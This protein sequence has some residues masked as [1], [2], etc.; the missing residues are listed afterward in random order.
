MKRLHQLPSAAW[1]NGG[2]IQIPTKDLPALARIKAFVFRLEGVF[3][4]G[5]AAAAIAS[6]QLHRLISMIDAGPLVRASGQYWRSLEWATRGGQTSIPFGLPAANNEVHRRHITWTIPFYDKRSQFPGDDCPV[7]AEYSD[8]VIQIETAAFAGLGAGTWD[9][10]ANLTGTLRVFALLD[11]PNDAPASQVKFG[12]VDLTGQAP[13]MDSGLYV[14]AFIYRES[15]AVITSAQVATVSM[16]VDGTQLADITRLSEYARIFNDLHGLGSDLETAHATTPVAGEQLPETP[17]AAAGSADT[18]SVPFVPLI[19]PAPGY[20]RSQGVRVESALRV[21]YTG[22]D[23]SIRV[24]FRKI[25]ARSES[26]AIQAFQR[27]GRT[28]VRSASQI[29]AKTGSKRGLTEGKA[30]LWRFLP[31]RA[32]SSR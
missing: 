24:G 8:K 2:N 21:D 7:G 25:V 30:H 28:D 17:A 26:D 29:G 19:T 10:L 3:T 23:N 20:K 15:A 22:T 31:L 14:D 4:T 16:Q 12:H 27:I 6:T 11:E 13:T 5:A 9:T 18:V 1:V 32:N